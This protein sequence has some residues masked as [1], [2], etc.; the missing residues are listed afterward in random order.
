MSD[1]RADGLR[2]CVGHRTMIERAEQSSFAVH[3]EISGSPDC[4]SS[5]VTR[6]YCIFGRELIDDTRNI[7]RMDRLLTGFAYRKLVKAFARLSIV[8]ECLPQMRVV[9]VLLQ[10]W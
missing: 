6:E 7:L 3:R 1:L 5:H 8:F 4:W 10:L 2:Q 9:L